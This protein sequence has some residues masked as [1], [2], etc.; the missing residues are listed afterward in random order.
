MSAAVARARRRIGAIV[1]RRDDRAIVIVRHA[2]Q[3]LLEPAALA[4]HHALVSR[5]ED[6]LEVLL[7]PVGGAHDGVRPLLGRLREAGV[8]VALDAATLDHDASL[9]EFASWIM[10]RAA[11]GDTAAPRDDAAVPS[12]GSFCGLVVRWRDLCNG[13]RLPGRSETVGP[14]SPAIVADA[15]E[16]IATGDP[17]EPVL[18]ALLDADDASTGAAL[19]TLSDA[20]RARRICMATRARWPLARRL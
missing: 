15:A 8:S 3:T 17:D 5:H 1:E 10:R 18:G 14:T 19:D 2:A 4:R 6:E 20:V 11:S 9:L 7:Q 12:G 13:W 16:H